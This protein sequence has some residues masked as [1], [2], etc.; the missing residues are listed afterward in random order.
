MEEKIIGGEKIKTLRC[1]N[2]KQ[3]IYK[4]KSLRIMTKLMFKE[5]T[6]QVLILQRLRKRLMLGK[7]EG[8]RRRGLP[9]MRW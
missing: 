1:Q 8:K 5:M 6:S 7:I 4:D 2:S 9:R 3:I